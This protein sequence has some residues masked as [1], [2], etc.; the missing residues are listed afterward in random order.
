MSVLKYNYK[1][2]KEWLKKIHGEFKDMLW[3]DEKVFHPTEL[4]HFEY[5]K[6][7]AVYDKEINPKKIIGIKYD[8][9]YNCPSYGDRSI[10][11]KY[12]L[13]WLKRLDRVIDNFKTKEEVIKHIQKNT[14][15]KA[16]LKYGGHYFTTS[17]QHRLCLAKYIELDEVKVS[18]REYKLDKE[19]FIREKFIVKNSEKLLNYGLIQENYKEDLTVSLIFIRIGN[20]RY[21]IR[22]EL[23]KYILEK[24]DNLSRCKLK[25]L[26]NIIKSI[27]CYK[28]LK[29]EIIINKKDLYML[30]YNI[31][32]VIQK[33]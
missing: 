18:V 12:M 6:E 33:F 1:E 30:D 31:I 7:Y 3:H 26:P 19:L 17:G 4:K 5:F 29:K 13:K 25:A 24:F 20:Q 2:R 32:K 9:G 14:D 28:D 8:F 10:D 27:F 23:I 11:W 15:P 22:K 16:V 21:T